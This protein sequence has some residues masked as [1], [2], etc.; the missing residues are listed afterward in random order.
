MEKLGRLHK[1]GRLAESRQMRSFAVTFDQAPDFVA[2]ALAQVIGL[3]V[4]PV[5]TRIADG[6]MHPPFGGE[7]LV[8]AAALVAASGLT[9]ST[10]VSIRGVSDGRGNVTVK[11]TAPKSD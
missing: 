9:P 4:L 10:R 5:P 7:I 6:K 1:A 3:P 11:I 2:R 8:L